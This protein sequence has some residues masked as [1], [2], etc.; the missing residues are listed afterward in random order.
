[1]PVYVIDTLKPKN[2]L[3]FPVVEAVDVAVEGYSSLADAVTHF[4]TDT[5]IATINTALETKADKTTTD[6]LQGQIDQIV[7]SAS[8]EAVVAPEVAQA[9]VGNNGTEFNTLKDRL[10][11]TDTNLEEF[12][13]NVFNTDN[14]LLNSTIVENAYY[15]GGTETSSDNYSY[16]I[17][18][19]LASKTYIISQARFVAYK[20]GAAVEEYVTNAEFTPSTDGNVYI[21]FY[22]NIESKG[23][24]AV[25]EKGKDPSKI[26][27]YQHPALSEGILAKETGSNDNIAI[28]QKAVTDAIDALDAKPVPVTKISGVTIKDGTDLSP[29]FVEEGDGGYMASGVG[30]TISRITY[31]NYRYFK[32]PVNGAA[33]YYI[34]DG[35]R[36]W[37]TTDENNN[38]V[39]CSTGTVNIGLPISATAKMLWVTYS[40]ASPNPSTRK[41]GKN[42]FPVTDTLYLLPDDV[43][44]KHL[45]ELG[46][47]HDFFNQINL[48]DS[49]ILVSNKYYYNGSYSDNDL[50]SVLIFNVESGKTYQFGCPIRFLDKQSV[51]ISSNLPAKSTYTADYSGTIYCSVQNAKSADWKVAELPND[52][53]TVNSR[54]V[55]SINP[56]MIAQTIGGS[57]SL[58]MSQAAVTQAALSNPKLYGKGYTQTTGDLS[59]GD[60][61]TLPKTNVKKNNVYSFMGYI[62]SF[63]KLFI[64]HGKSTYDSSWVEI[65]DT[66]LI[67]HN[68]LNADAT[69]EYEHGLTLSDYIYVQITVGVNSAVANITSNGTRYTSPSFGWFGDANGDTYVESAGSVL[70]N[71]VFTWSS[72]DFR[73]STWMFGDSYFSMSSSSRWVK[74]LMDAGYGDNVLLNAYP[75]ENTAAALTALNNSLEYYGIPNAIVWCLGMNDGSD[76]D[77]DTP[78]SAWMTGVNRVL[79]VC[80]QYAITPIFATIPTVPDIYHEGKNNYVRNSGYRYIDFAKAVGASGDGS[81]FSG[82][83]SNDNVH[84]AVPGAIALYHRAIADCPEITFSNP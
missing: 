41:I 4:A 45:D 47:I 74:Y 12:K 2:G 66:K 67:V 54:G 76:T 14:L 43:E 71:C 77:D 64:G 72:G 1:M 31:E 22:H 30:G 61:L 6:S 17:V 82:M 29:E 75:G 26:G 33:T 58:L 25:Y 10:D 38:V 81:W 63:T 23:E 32:L 11:N 50:Y 73:K 79:K 51:N 28:S 52:V 48:F 3:D 36:W 68:Y 34:D 7:I 78:S 40:T 59:D 80:E 53:D 62:T 20:T 18:P 21:S 65:T 15:T 42:K 57:K 35:C 24:W 27:T 44:D 69:A 37:F 84:P 60:S 5:V 13:G 16:A 55:P 70:T 46:N 39:D 56:S 9:R 83:L 49:A 8:A 19:M